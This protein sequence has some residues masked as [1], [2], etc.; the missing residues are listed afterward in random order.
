[1][2]EYGQ[3]CLQ[4]FDGCHNSRTGQAP[5]HPQFPPAGHP[6]A[7]MP[8]DPATNVSFVRFRWDKDGKHALNVEG[9][10]RIVLGVHTLGPALYPMST[11]LLPAILDA[12]LKDRVAKKYAI[13]PTPA[14]IESACNQLCVFGV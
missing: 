13:V 7:P 3:R 12:H 14:R 11:V 6:D 5:Y 1:M 9:I 8:V 10:E 2:I 4:A